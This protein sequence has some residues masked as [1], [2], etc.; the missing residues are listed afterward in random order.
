MGYYGN[1]RYRSW[2]SRGLG[3]SGPSKFSVLSELFG[4]ALAQIRDAFKNLDEDA[5]DELFSD[6]GSI[7]GDAAERYARK[8]FPSWE[9]GAIKLSGQTMERLVELVPPY[10]EPE[11]RPESS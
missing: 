6:Y 2:R 10:L 3:R 4:N 8:T 1:R 5:L 9:S 11:Q 7:Y